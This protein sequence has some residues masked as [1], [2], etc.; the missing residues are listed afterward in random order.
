MAEH[1]RNLKATRTLN[2]HEEAVRTL[3]ETLKLVGSGLLIGGRVEKIDR[4][5][6]I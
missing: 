5:L 4:H 3:Y 1:S 2:V 6:S